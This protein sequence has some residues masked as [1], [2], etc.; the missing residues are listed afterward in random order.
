M[1]DFK[2]LHPGWSDAQDAAW[3][4]VHQFKHGEKTGAEAVAPFLGKSPATLSNMVN[5]EQPHKL[6]LEDAMSLVLATRD[7]RVLQVFARDCG[8]AVIKLL[9][10]THASERDV[11]SSFA[12]WQADLGK[13]NATIQK[14]LQDGKVTTDELDLI[15]ASA[16]A[17]MGAFF[18][19]LQTLEK[20]EQRT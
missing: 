7:P 16:H 10:M 4:T 19:F 1:V 18:E 5:P 11:L 9:D 15:R 2:K 8:Y 6:D 20:M 12:Q 14:A 13:T 17:H 3:Q